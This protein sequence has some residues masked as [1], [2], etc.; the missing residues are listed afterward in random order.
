MSAVDN[1][2]NNSDNSNGNG[3]APADAANDQN[4]QD[5]QNNNNGDE[6]GAFMNM[7]ES[8]YTRV[9]DGSIPGMDSA[10]KLAQYYIRN[11]RT[12]EEAANA[13]I[14]Y[15]NWKSAA[16]GFSLGLPGL[17]FLPATISAD[18]AATLAFN[19]QTIC[20]IAI[21]GGHDL[22]HEGVKALSY[23]C[24]TGEPV[25]VLLKSM[26]TTITKVLARGLVNAIPRKLLGKINAMVGA[27]LF[28]KF[29]SKGIIQLGLAV[30]LL[31]GLLGGFIDYYNSNSCGSTAI[32][33]FIK[34][35]PSETEEANPDSKSEAAT[36]PDSTAV[37]SGDSQPAV[38]SPP[39]EPSE[40][41]P[42]PVPSETASN[43]EKKDETEESV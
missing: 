35:H 31:G 29:S 23:A 37:S 39:S 24:L 19:L 12:P 17:V 22:K 14:S 30:P 11:Y 26:G 10:D 8:L 7:L 27:K 18:V 36:A 40:A 21:I 42:S 6:Q 16:T 32:E 9:V 38:V 2:N 33:T 4:N 3:N 34:D 1:N 20:A 13:L 15:Q 28:T 25:D 43:T 41:A 5:G